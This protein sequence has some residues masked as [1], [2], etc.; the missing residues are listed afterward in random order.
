MRRAEREMKD[1]AEIDGVI[2]GCRICRL[3]FAD[4]DEPYIVPLSFGY[5]GEA[6][7]FHT[8]IKGRKIDCIEANPR[9]CFELERNVRLEGGGND[10][11]DWT[12]SYES[13]IG[14]GTLGE[15]VETEDRI[16]GL[17]R[18]M[19]QYTGREWEFQPEMLEGARIWRLDIESVT[20]KRSGPE[21]S[22]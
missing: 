1:R 9:V 8:A 18:I 12:F 7:Y 21:L 2:R 4:S 20:G 13:V 22:G 6:L 17:N 3:A 14:Y 10:P 16:F 11:C 19:E 15:L 5:D